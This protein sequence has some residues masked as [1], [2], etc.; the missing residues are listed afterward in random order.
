MEHGSLPPRHTLSVKDA[1]ALEPF[2][3]ALM[4]HKEPETW[5]QLRA[6]GLKRIDKPQV[7]MKSIC[8]LAGGELKVNYDKFAKKVASQKKE[9][10]A[11]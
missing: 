6:R 8:Y 10:E 5:R 3:R 2:Y 7:D 11:K 9:K 1:A 4:P